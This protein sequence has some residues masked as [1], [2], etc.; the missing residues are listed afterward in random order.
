MFV[1]DQVGADRAPAGYMGVGSN[2]FPDILVSSSILLLWSLM[3]VFLEHYLYV[4]FI[5]FY[6][7]CFMNS[8]CC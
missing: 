3:L 1:V 6:V 5:L 4:L 2:K 8:I 7:F